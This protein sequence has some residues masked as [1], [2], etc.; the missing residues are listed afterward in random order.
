MAT[1]R[2]AEEVQEIEEMTA[3]V[4]GA[5]DSLKHILLRTK[6]VQ[7]A[8]EAERGRRHLAVL[9]NGLVKKRKGLRNG[10]EE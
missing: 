5:D 4:L 2:K 10:N 7:V 9:W 1:T 8:K 3:H 6:D